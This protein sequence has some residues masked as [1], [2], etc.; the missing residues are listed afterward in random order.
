MS[1]LKIFQK[2]LEEEIQGSK[3]EFIKDYISKENI[4]T[5]ENNISFFEDIP[6]QDLEEIFIKLIELVYEYTT[7]K[8]NKKMGD[9]ARKFK[10]TNQD[11]T[12]PIR[13]IEK[14]L[15]IMQDYQDM[16][17]RLYGINGRI[18]IT[19]PK[20]IKE[21]Y[22]QNNKMIDDLKSKKFKIISKYKYYDTFNPSKKEIK[23]FLQ[24][25]KDKYKLQNI[26]LA[27]KQ[28]IDEIK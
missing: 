5:I 2:L 27:Q 4:R 22:E 13:K 14:D 21:I 18:F 10:L 17:I 26:S 9:M 15:K 20:E 8:I 23:E 19:P 3:E 11:N 6:E 7:P 28:L 16:I 1:A 12:K 24:E 25:I